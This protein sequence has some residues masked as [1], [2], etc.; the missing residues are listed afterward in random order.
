MKI[1]D[2]DS[3][4][5]NNVEIKLSGRVLMNQ[6]GNE[7][8]KFDN[9]LEID[10]EIDLNSKLSEAGV[11]GENRSEHFHIDFI[12]PLDSVAHVIDTAKI[13]RLTYK[14][15]KEPYFRASILVGINS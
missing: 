4:R 14:E 5:V 1:C 11:I 7:T 9:N 6:G 8:I 15:P 10:S 2:F 3:V 12:H 13:N